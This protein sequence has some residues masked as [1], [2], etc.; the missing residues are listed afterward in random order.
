M[1]FY[2]QFALIG[3]DFSYNILKP[4]AEGL[5]PA[6]VSSSKREFQIFFAGCSFDFQFAELF[7]LKR[8]WMRKSILHT[9]LFRLRELFISLSDH[10]EVL[11]FHLTKTLSILDREIPW[12]ALI[13]TSGT[14]L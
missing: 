10:E 13:L 9:F 11:M 2:C 12:S 5:E 6:T 8:A 3:I 14:L 7:S 1:L 4:I